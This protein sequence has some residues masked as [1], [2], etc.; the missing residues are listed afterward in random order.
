MHLPSD[1]HTL[2]DRF[3]QSSYES[4][5]PSG[6][7][8]MYPSCCPNRPNRSPSSC[9]SC[10]SLS[11]LPPH[12]RFGM[13]NPH[14][15]IPIPQ[16]PFPHLTHLDSLDSLRLTSTHLSL[17]NLHLKRQIS[18]RNSRIKSPLLT[19]TPMPSAR[20]SHCV[21]L[22]AVGRKSNS[23]QSPVPHR[24]S[25]HKGLNDPFMIPKRYFYHAHRCFTVDGR[26]IDFAPSSCILQSCTS[27]HWYIWNGTFGIIHPIPP[28][29]LHNAVVDFSLL[30][31][32]SAD[33]AIS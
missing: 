24:K 23:P 21:G 25:S 22:L 14:S 1:S 13:Y 27:V 9:S 15:P 29:P 18:N 28:L 4:A 2:S 32:A 31:L 7:L 26:R 33:R 5:S 17:S 3:S 6:T 11:M 30:R 10:S 12:T 19:S 16:S 8:L 20:L